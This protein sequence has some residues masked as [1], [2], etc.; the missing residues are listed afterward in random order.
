MSD[1]NATVPLAPLAETPRR[2]GAGRAVL[3][4]VLVVAVL[5][6]GAA[7]VAELWARGRVSDLVGDKVRQVFSLPD[8][9]PV[10]VEVHG[11]S[12]ILQA[13]SGTINS[14]TVSV[15]NVGVGDLSGDLVLNATGIPVDTDL[16]V[17]NVDATVSVGEDNIQRL[18][19][20]LTAAVVNNV[21]FA[22]PE[23]L[24]GTEFSTPT[25]EFFGIKVPGIT[26]S[27]GVGVE[28]YASDGWLGFTPSSIEIGGQQ[29]TA[30]DLKKQFGSIAENLL[31]TRSFC[32]ASVLPAAISLDS[33]EVSGNE[34]L[35]KLSAENQVLS[36]AALSE[37]GSCS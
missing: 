31:Q 12:V 37:R 19:G 30:E 3:I 26:A 34:L 14:A 18:S 28:P 35:I 4:T 27:A 36:R 2:H 6:A 17:E 29:T 10:S 15:D 21:R 32:V 5:V 8:S 25:M 24:I 13:L 7:V 20:L 22:E 33:A 11:F 23:I 1:A 16:P 9:H